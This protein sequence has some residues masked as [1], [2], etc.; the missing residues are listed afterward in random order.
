MLKA[1]FQIVINFFKNINLNKH[2]KILKSNID[3]MD[4]YIFIPYI[5][6]SVIGIIMVYSASSNIAT[7]IGGTPTGYLIRQSM[8]VVISLI[9]VL[10]CLCGQN[11]FVR[12][13]AFLGLFCIAMAGGL[14][15]LKFFGHSVNGAAGWIPLGPLHIQPAETAKIYI[16]LVMSNILANH[17]NDLIHK[18]RKPV[19]V[20]S[21]FVFFMLCMILIQPDLGGTIINALIFVVIIFASGMNWKGATLISSSMILGGWIVLKTALFIF[22]NGSSNYQIQRILAYGNPFKYEQGIGHQLVNSYYA[23]SNG[24]IFGVGLG[25]SIQKTGYLPEPNTDFIMSVISEEL[26]LVGVLLILFLLF[27]II[28]KA[29]QMGIRANNTYDALVS[30]GVGTYL[31]VQ[32]YFN[33]GG[34][35]GLLPITGVTF[36][37][38]SYG[39]SS[40]LTLALCI[41]MLL[42][43]SA[44]QKIQRKHKLK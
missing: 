40:M 9:I 36:P 42:V 10:I 22:R 26:G 25:N 43:I 16:I 8:F 27:I 20:Q 15:W 7:Q 41:G 30:Y 37:F 21:G 38:I 14:I 12:K 31:L 1:A 39:G 23:L 28:V 33:I 29:F 17:E 5:M 35:I 19:L 44:K 11:L 34:V 32:S 2:L 6:L 18:I 3:A 24:G 13:G 4:Y